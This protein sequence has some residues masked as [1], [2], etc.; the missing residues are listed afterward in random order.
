MKAL[1]SLRILV[2]LALSINFVA[3]T[4]DDGP[5]E[6]SAYGKGIF[7]TN[8]GPYNTGTGTITFYDRNTGEVQ[9]DVFKLVNNRELGNVVQSMNLFNGQAYIIVNNSS[10]IE[11]AD[12][13]SMKSKATITGFSFPRYMQVINDKK[14]YVSDWAGLV[15]VVDL[16]ANSITKSITAGTGPEVMLK[17]GDLVFVLNGGGFSIDSSITVIN[18]STDQV[19]KTLEVFHRPTGIVQDA[20]GKVWVMCSGRGFNGWPSESDT[21]GKLVRIDPVTLEIDQTISFGSTS[22]HPEKLVINQAGNT[23]YFLFDQGIFK[24]NT[25]LATGTPARV[26]THPNLYALAMDASN[27]HLLASDPLDF[28]SNG[29]VLR[30]DAS[31][32]AMIDSIQAGVIPGSM[33]VKE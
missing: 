20:S 23:L 16:A 33:V 31:S 6:D 13:A 22:V 8:E 32:G 11:V 15:H 26:C 10:K 4:K 25:T 18:A 19:V 5:A 21:E 1:T 24:Y 2:F 17:S 30:Y 9:Q 27:N 28:Q 12:A 7:I 3:C 14:A 29:W